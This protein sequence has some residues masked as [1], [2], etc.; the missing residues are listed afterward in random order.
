MPP[1]IA[2]DTYLQTNSFIKYDPALNR[3]GTHSTI[4]KT[5]LLNSHYGNKF[6]VCL[7]KSFFKIAYFRENT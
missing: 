1:K 3:K 5:L 2:F 7:H 6:I 4:P